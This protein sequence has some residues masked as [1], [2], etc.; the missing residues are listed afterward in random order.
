MEKR[1][2]KK[3]AKTLANMIKTSDIPLN[4]IYDM[5]GELLNLDSEYFMEFVY[6]NLISLLKRI[7]ISQMIEMDMHILKNFCLLEG[8]DIVVA[9]NGMISESKVTSRGRIYLT[10]YRLILSGTQEVRSAQSKMVGPGRPGLIGMA[11]RSGITRH[12]KAVRRAI[13]KALRKDITSL[14]LV[15]W[16]YY[17]PIHE[18]QNITKGKIGIS[19]SVTVETEKKPITMSINVV[20]M[21]LKT[22]SQE[23]YEV[24]SNQQ[25]SQMNELLLKYQ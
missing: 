22:Q 9:F 16:G 2:A 11:F 24:Q 15:E 25:L 13:T 23:D 5:I 3:L 17:F 7:D 20:P 4:E 6:P 12:R 8:E 10:N 18:A 1:K 19:Y 14:N 21:K